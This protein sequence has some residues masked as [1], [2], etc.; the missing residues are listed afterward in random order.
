[1][2]PLL[3]LMLLAPTAIIERPIP[4][5][6]RLLS[7][8]LPPALDGRLAFAYLIARSEADPTDAPGHVTAEG[9]AVS[10]RLDRLPS[11]ELAN[12]GTVLSGF[13]R[14]DALW[15]LAAHGWVKRIEPM[16]G[17]LT[18]AML[19]AST[20]AREVEATQ[21]SESVS[22]VHAVSSTPRRARIP[23]PRPSPI[24]GTS[25]T[26]ASPTSGRCR[27]RSRRRCGRSPWAP[28]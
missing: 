25:T 20:T 8:T 16:S 6:Q 27:T 14:W 26:T 19:P 11:G 15:T 23:R 1:M 18:P 3:M 21:L 2:T 24:A 10:I 12:V 7:S 13:C 5:G 28:G 9:L 22:A 4:A 17:G